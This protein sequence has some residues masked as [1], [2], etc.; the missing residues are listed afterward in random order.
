MTTTPEASPVSTVPATSIPPQFPL[1]I[2][3]VSREE[4]YGQDDAHQP[5]QL[6]I[7][8]TLPSDLQGHVFIVS[9][10]GSIDSKAIPDT[11][12]V[13]PAADGWTPLYNGDGMIYRLDF[14]LAAQG[15]VSLCSRIA[16]PPCYY[17]DIATY[18]EP[19]F[20][21]L[22]FNNMG[23]ARQS[24]KLGSRNQLNT[25]FVPMQFGA[26]EHG[27][28]LVTW[29]PGRP[30][31]IDPKTLATVTPMGSN[32]EWKPVNPFLTKAVP[33][34][35][36]LVVSSAHPCFDSY[37]KQIFTVNVGKSLSTLLSVSEFIA[38][39]EE[40]VERIDGWLK[41]V[42][43]LREIARLIFAFLRIFVGFLRDIWHF[44][45]KFFPSIKNNDFVD[46]LRW[47]GAGA[48]EKWKVVLPDGRP[49]K[50]AE[51][52]HQMGVTRNYVVLMDTAFKLSPEELLPPPTYKKEK[53]AEIL[54]RD[55]LD[56]PQ[57]TETKLYIVPRR[58]LQAGKPTVTAKQLVIPRETAH[59]LVDY[60][61]VDGIVIH[62]MHVCACD[63]SEWLNHSDRTVNQPNTTGDNPRA[64]I[65]VSPMDVNWV[66]RYTID[67]V[68]GSLTGQMLKRQDAY[69]WGPS[70]YAYREMRSG[71]ID[72]LYWNCWGSWNQLLTQHIF[73]LYKDYK[74]RTIPASDIPAIAAIGKASNLFRLETG[75]LNIVDAY[76]FPTNYFG[77]SPQF[78]PRP[79]NEDDSTHGYITC[80]V[81]YDD[82]HSDPPVKSEIWIFDAANLSQGAI[83]KLSHPQLKFGFTVHTAWVAQVEERNAA[84]NIPVRQDYEEIL[85]HQPEADR[86]LIQ[87]LF[88][89]YVYPNFP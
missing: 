48:L 10:V 73:S 58:E 14:D 33:G 78:V 56:Y 87:E 18:E 35:F 52:A 84:Y 60:E 83:C 28:M 76:T 77:S 65:V 6:Q 17:A 7:D 50:I 89:Q 72:N 51:T 12:I 16:K 19:K 25:A 55:L 24:S 49:V 64:G 11:P 13:L 40:W 4:F 74:Y 62:L 71:Q 46:L 1:S 27:R 81:L 66:G 30:Y 67:G 39:S 88:D 59:F 20:V 86:E 79:G 15:K 61:D 57:T 31:E 21:E 3:S 82:P 8:G 41:Q 37:T 5:L 2:L 38:Q 32:A 34:P 43:F 45:Q 9:P 69:T 36:P 29:D 53:S 22:K 26:E 85:K 42:P 70:L 23:I 44:L 75:T 63:A 80:T 54:L 68:T 47:D